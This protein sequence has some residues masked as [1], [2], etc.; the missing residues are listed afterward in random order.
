MP[1]MQFVE[2][3]VSLRLPHSQ[4]GYRGAHDRVATGAPGLEGRERGGVGTEDL[5]WRQL[6]LCRTGAE[7]CCFEDR[8]EVKSNLTDTSLFLC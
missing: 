7:I 2:I 8:V 3:S 6:A 5:Q 4:N 1:H